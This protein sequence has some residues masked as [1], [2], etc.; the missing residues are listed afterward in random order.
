MLDVQL[1]QMDSFYYTIETRK[2]GMYRTIMEIPA[3]VFSE[4]SNPSH[5]R[6][7]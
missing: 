1:Q 4:A 2:E 5:R 3:M 7:V 6:K